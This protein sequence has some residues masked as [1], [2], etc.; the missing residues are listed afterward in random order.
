MARMTGPKCKI[1]RREGV[2]LY[3]KG[4]KCYSEK[5]PMNKR[6]YPPGQHGKNRRRRRLSTYGVQFRE[7]Q[8]I[9]RIYG[10]L[11]KQFKK[12]ID[13]A[14]SSSG[15]TGESLMQE[16]ES[17]FDNMVYRSGFATSRPQARQFIRSG[18]FKLNG[19]IVDIPSV[20][21]EPEDVIEPVDIGK[22][23]LRQGFTL[24][25][26]LEA[27]VKEKYVKVKRLPN[28]EDEV[29]EDIDIQLIVEFYSR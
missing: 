10:I 22:I 7:K 1:C 23:H 28:Q 29:L 16:L 3:L 24:P 14:L 5:C 15:V 18:L 11:E 12:Y 19:R 20:Q 17:R 2:K 8:K 4:E 21:L 6:P 27:N 25:D 9:K 13:K 26:W